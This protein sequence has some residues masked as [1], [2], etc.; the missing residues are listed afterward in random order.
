MNAQLKNVKLL[1]EVKTEQGLS[2]FEQTTNKN[3]IIRIEIAVSALKEFKFSNYDNVRDIIIV[4][5]LDDMITWTVI[6]PTGYCDIAFSLD[7]LILEDI[8][9]CK[10]IKNIQIYCWTN[11]FPE[12]LANLTTIESVYIWYAEGEKNIFDEIEKYRKLKNLKCVNYHGYGFIE[13]YHK[14]MR[15]SFGN[16]AGFGLTFRGNLN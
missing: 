15:K 10:H 11:T 1:K 13:K 2:V 6:P 16:I 7:N 9:L 5:N 4:D 12:I 14:K 8:L 3:E